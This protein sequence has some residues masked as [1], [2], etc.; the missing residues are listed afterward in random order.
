MVFINDFKY[1]LVELKAVNI[2]EIV[3]KAKELRQTSLLRT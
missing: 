3:L 1:I 2:L